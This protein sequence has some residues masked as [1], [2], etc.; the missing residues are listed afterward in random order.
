M[1]LLQDAVEKA[2]N[3]V[4]LFQSKVMEVIVPFQERMS[5][6]S[7]ETV[8]QNLSVAKTQDLLAERMT[9]RIRS[10]ESGGLS[11]KDTAGPLRALQSG[12]VGSSG[13]IRQ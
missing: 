13:Q 4:A 10:L 2:M 5:L 3:D 1:A 6:I 12:L 11:R 7:Q 8:I 9:A